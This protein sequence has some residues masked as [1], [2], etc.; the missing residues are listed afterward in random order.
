MALSI[1]GISGIGGV[2]AI[3]QSGISIGGAKTSGTGFADTLANAL[4]SVQNKVGA[5]D[6]AAM[7]VATGDV[8][9]SEY[10]TAATDAQ[11]TVQLALAV[12]NRAVEAFNEI[13]RMPV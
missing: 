10:L 7:G 11:L 13:M 6:Q 5:A 12:R 9:A 8:T 3:P 2:S 1:S 4:D